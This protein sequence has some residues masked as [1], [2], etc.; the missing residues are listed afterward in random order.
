MVY[1]LSSPLSFA[2]QLS[3]RN[4]TL[5]N[6]LVAC[7]ISAPLDADYA[8]SLLLTREYTERDAQFIRRN[9]GKLPLVHKL[10]QARMRLT[11]SIPPINIYN[12][13]TKTIECI[14]T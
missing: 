10:R 2:V 5:H 14:F 9:F 3:D 7:G 12:S 11:E 4:S 6:Q 1:Y 8:V 13:K